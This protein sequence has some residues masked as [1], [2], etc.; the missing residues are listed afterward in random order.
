MRY[1]AWRGIL[2]ATMILALAARWSD[3]LPARNGK[4]WAASASITTMKVRDIAAGS[5]IRIGG[6]KFVAIGGGRWMATEPASTCDDGLSVGGSKNFDYTGGEQTFTACA[7]RSYKLEVWGAQGGDAT[8]RAGG[9]GGYAVGSIMSSLDTSLFINVGGKGQSLYSATGYTNGG[10]NG[11]GFGYHVYMYESTT[12]VAGGGGAT[13]ITTST[14]LL[15]T[16][17]TN[18]AAIIIVAGAGGGAN[19]TNYANCGIG[20]NGGGYSGA[21]GTSLCSGW[22]YS[23]RK[24]YPGTQTNGGCSNGNNACGDFG[25]GGDSHVSTGETNSGGGAGYYGG[26]GAIFSSGSGGSGYIGSS[27]LISANGITK[28]MTC[29]NC[30]TST[31]DATRTQSNTCVSATATADCSK[32]GNGYARITRLN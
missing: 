5:T 13:S 28:H 6:S 27:N 31:V 9:Y 19:Y 14:G 2:A 12:S 23:G 29:Y 8:S 11:G 24:S 22:T 7:G 3:E 17:K 21:E 15:Q 32:T 30:A 4:V 1:A 26:S 16:F 20:G 10:Y 18:Q 25:R